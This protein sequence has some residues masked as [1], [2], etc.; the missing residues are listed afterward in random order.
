[1]RNFALRKNLASEF[2]QSLSTTQNLRSLKFLKAALENFSGLS[3]VADDATLSLL[4]SDIHTIMGSCFNN[5]D[6]LID[7]FNA[8]CLADLPVSMPAEI[9]SLL[10]SNRTLFDNHLK[11]KVR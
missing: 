8:D 9:G 3:D 10:D 1:M 2:S 7:K 5:V 4:N 6:S 11:R